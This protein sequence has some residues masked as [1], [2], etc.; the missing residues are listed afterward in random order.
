MYNFTPERSLSTP[1]SLA[2]DY[3]DLLSSS[4]EKFHMSER[5][6]ERKQ[7]LLLLLL[8]T[9]PPKSWSKEEIAIEFNCSQYLARTAKT[10]RETKGLLPSIEGKRAGNRISET[11]MEKV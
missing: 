10:L 7:L 8:L 3:E 11:L 5:H 2:A 4:K 9:L 6:D 1:K